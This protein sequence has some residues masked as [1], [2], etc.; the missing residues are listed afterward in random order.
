[1]I[2]SSEELRDSG[3]LGF[4]PLRSCNRDE[5]ETVNPTAKRE[6]GW[7][8]LIAF[9]A[10]THRKALMEQA[11]EIY[12]EPV[13][14]HDDELESAFDLGFMAGWKAARIGEVVAPWAEPP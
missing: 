8:A 13:W 5:E 14:G 1:M 3:G 9:E 4:L 12:M 6:A 7:D 11:E 2:D 10:D